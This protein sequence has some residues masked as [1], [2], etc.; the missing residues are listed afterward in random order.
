MSEPRP[1][2]QWEREAYRA[3]E[4]VFQPP[5]M[6]HDGWDEDA[7]IRWIRQSGAFTWVG[8]RLFG[9]PK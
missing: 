8:K 5:P 3:D 1:I 2:E 7:W 6:P 9:A 4:Y